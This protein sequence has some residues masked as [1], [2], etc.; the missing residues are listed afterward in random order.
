VR[1]IAEATG[2]GFVPI[3][4]V[5]MGAIHSLNVPHWVVV[6]H[7]DEKSVLFNDPYPPKGKKGLRLSRVKFQKII[8][9]IDVKI[10]MSP[11]VLLVRSG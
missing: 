11:S 8:D 7:V 9:D 1:D 10:G 6:T 4:L 2:A 5:H 3:A